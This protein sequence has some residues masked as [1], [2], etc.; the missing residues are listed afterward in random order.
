M[1]FYEY[2]C[3]KCEERF[4]LMR[5]LADRD[6][7]ATCPSCGQDGAKREFA[8]IQATSSRSSGGGATQ[9]PPCGRTGFS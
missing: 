1:P 3:P 5:S 2:R 8:R 7:P 4:D 6:L 9:T